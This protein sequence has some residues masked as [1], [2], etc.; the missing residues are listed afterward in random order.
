MIL[1]CA[2]RRKDSRARQ[3][4]QEEPR[5]K[6]N[7]EVFQALREER[8]ALVG[9]EAAGDSAVVVEDSAEVDAVALA[10]RVVVQERTATAG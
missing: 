8:A 7:R 9:R 3:A 2:G 1:D 10:R 5:W 4:L 6:V